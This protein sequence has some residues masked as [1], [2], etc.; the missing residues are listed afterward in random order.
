MY[1][2]V[3][4]CACRFGELLIVILPVIACECPFDS[5]FFCP[6]CLL[7]LCLRALVRGVPALA[8]LFFVVVVRH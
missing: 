5:L 8:I 1:V 2:C 4:V 7:W 6:F 3:C